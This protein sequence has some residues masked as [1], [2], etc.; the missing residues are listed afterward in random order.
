MAGRSLS[1]SSLEATPHVHGVGDA[2]V[3]S[4]CEGIVDVAWASRL[5]LGL[6]HIQAAE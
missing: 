4:I 1:G 3:L 5:H 6:A 2:P